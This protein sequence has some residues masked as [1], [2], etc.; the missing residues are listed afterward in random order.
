MTDQS[1]QARSG[2][3][4]SEKL[5]GTSS[6][7]EDLLPAAVVKVFSKRCKCCLSDY[8]DQI[9][10]W[11]VSGQ[12]NL[13]ISKELAKGGEAI[14]PQAIGRHKKNHIHDLANIRAFHIARANM[15]TRQEIIAQINLSKIELNESC[16][17]DYRKFLMNRIDRLLKQLV[18]YDTKMSK[19][20]S[21]KKVDNRTINV[22]NISSAAIDDHDEQKE[23]L[24]QLRFIELKDRMT[25]LQAGIASG[26]LQLLD[27]ASDAVVDGDVNDITILMDRAMTD[28]EL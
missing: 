22:A 26:D 7:Y 18:D 16:E 27:E 14:T 8:Y 23:R 28:D 9:N 11:I 4:G 5:I 25:K 21:I 6:K 2:D 3:L 17:N 13:W 12:T 10:N 19:Q 24:D 15:D 1:I 20:P